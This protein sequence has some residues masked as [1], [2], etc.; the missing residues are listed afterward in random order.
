MSDVTQAIL[1]AQNN[2]WMLN[3]SSGFVLDDKSDLNVSY[4]YY[5]ADDYQDNSSFGVPY[6]PGAQE[7]GITATLIRRLTKN[8]RVSLKYGY[9]HGTDDTYGGNQNYSSQLV[10]SS[11]QFRF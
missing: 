11:L 10:Y 9:F 2:Y 4:F 6:G 8:L 1:V 7:Q 5:R 3:L